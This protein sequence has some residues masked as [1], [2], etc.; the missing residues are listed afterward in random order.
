MN[1]ETD[2][3]FTT[4][5]VYGDI[6][7]TGLTLVTTCTEYN[8]T[9]SV[10]YFIC[11]TVLYYMGVQHRW[12]SRH[13][14]GRTKSIKPPCVDREACVSVT[15]IKWGLC[16]GH[17]TWHMSDWVSIN[18]LVPYKNYHVYFCGLTFPNFIIKYMWTCVLL[19]M[20]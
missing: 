2:V 13:T 14:N 10:Q 16:I 20:F 6:S 4:N 9:V 7:L 17:G 5:N 15:W 12:W 8:C 11:S 3:I 19:L 18:I 1:Q